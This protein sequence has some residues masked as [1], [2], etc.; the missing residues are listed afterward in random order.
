MILV[1]DRKLMPYYWLSVTDDNAPFLAI[2]EHTN[3][4]KTKQYNNKH[5]LYIAKYIDTEDKLF[6]MNEEELFNLYL[7]YLKEINLL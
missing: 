5:L 4:L 7:N 3:L 2:I 6:N 1:L